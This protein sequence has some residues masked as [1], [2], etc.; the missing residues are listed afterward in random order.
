MSPTGHEHWFIVPSERPL[1]VRQP[2]AST[3]RSKTA[4]SRTP[5]D[6]HLALQAF[7]Q[8]AENAAF[9]RLAAN[10]FRHKKISQFLVAFAGNL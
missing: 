2:L 9:P 8:F 1:S 5:G 10:D 3:S 7:E 6:R 4:S